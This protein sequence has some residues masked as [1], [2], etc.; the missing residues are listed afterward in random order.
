MDSLKDMLL[1]KDEAFA[2]LVGAPRNACYP[3]DLGGCQIRDSF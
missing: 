3:V 1:C 2:G